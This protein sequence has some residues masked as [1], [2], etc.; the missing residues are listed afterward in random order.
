MGVPAGMLFDPQ[1]LRVSVRLEASKL[2]TARFPSKP[3]R[4]LVKIGDSSNR[5]IEL[6]GPRTNS[7]PPPAGIAIEEVIEKR[8]SV[9]APTFGS[10]AT[11]AADGSNDGVNTTPVTR[12]ERSM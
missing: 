1:R 7:N 11:I 8:S 5:M 9:R 12:G 3:S 2:T 4:E 10:V 6:D